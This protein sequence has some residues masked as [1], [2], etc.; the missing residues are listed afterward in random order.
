[1]AAPPA[2]EASGPPAGL[3]AAE[4]AA[5]A[6][7]ARPAPAPAVVPGSLDAAVAAAAPTEAPAPAEAAPAPAPRRVAIPGEALPAAPARPKAPLPVEGG[8]APVPAPLS[9]APGPDAGPAAAG[10]GSSGSG[11]AGT[12]TVVQPGVPA[13][14]AP[15]D[16]ELVVPLRPSRTG[17]E[18]EGDPQL[19]G[20]QSAPA[21]AVRVEAREASEI[22]TVRERPAGGHTLL[23][24]VGGVLLAG[25]L[26]A[27]GLLLYNGSRSASSSTVSV[28]W[29]H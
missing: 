28:S 21:A 2:S 16:R 27:G 24:V 4:L 5:A 13:P 26:G 7:L 19:A 3:S 15:A 29:G 8:A 11:T 17:P 12:R 20:R 18:P 10:A 1:V 25:A 14:P 6:G 9:A 23:W 22:A